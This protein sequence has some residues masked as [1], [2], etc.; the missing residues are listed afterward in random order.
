[1]AVKCIIKLTYVA[2]LI[3]TIDS[4]VK[5]KLIT[6]IQQLQ[7]A[8]FVTN[9]QLKCQYDF[10]NMSQVQKDLF[11]KMLSQKHMMKLFSVRSVRT[12]PRQ[13]K[14]KSVHLT[15]KRLVVWSHFHM[16]ARPFHARCNKLIDSRLEL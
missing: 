13:C 9:H 6:V 15:R 12:G 8:S 14:V 11:V 16:D 5:A 2:K 10:K 4:A 7:I 1:M 3:I